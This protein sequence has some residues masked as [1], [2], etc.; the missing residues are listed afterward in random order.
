MFIFELEVERARGLCQK[1]N[2][3]CSS[4]FSFI[5]NSSS[6]FLVPRP[7]HGVFVLREPLSLSVNSRNLF[8]K[9][10]PA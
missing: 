9:R 8:P 1:P 7:H 3:A 5:F 6:S 4:V 10:L 2:T